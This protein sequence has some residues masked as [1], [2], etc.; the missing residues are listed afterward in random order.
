MSNASKKAKAAIAEVKD[1]ARARYASIR[2]SEKGRMATDTT[3]ATA[4]G[5]GCAFVNGAY[6]DASMEIAGID[7]PYTAMAGAAALAL[8]AQTGKREIAAAGYGALFEF[9][10]NFAR[11]AGADWVNS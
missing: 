7:V 8:G 6:S 10:C 5:L 2:E 11:N 4:T 3:I 9:G 1:K